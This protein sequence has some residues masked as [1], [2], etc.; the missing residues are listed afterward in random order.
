MY[1]LSNQREASVSDPV[2]QLYRM[3]FG[4]WVA[5]EP[6]ATITHT[7]LGTNRRTSKEPVQARTKIMAVINEF[8]WMTNKHIA[9]LTGLPLNTVQTT[10]N[11]LYGKQKLERKM[12]KENVDTKPVCL[13][14]KK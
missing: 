14:R 6:K 7:I 1:L 10:T 11:K 5:P 3:F 4:D 8:D 9:E 12:N 2:T 13:Y